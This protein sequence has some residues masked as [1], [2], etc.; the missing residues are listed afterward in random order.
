M[1]VFLRV[2]IMSPWLGEKIFSWQWCCTR[3]DQKTHL[4][5]PIVWD[6]GLANFIFAKLPLWLFWSQS[7]GRV[8]LTS[9]GSSNPT[10]SNRN[11]LQFAYLFLFLVWDFIA[12][13]PYRRHWNQAAWNQLV[14]GWSAAAVPSCQLGRKQ[15][16]GVRKTAQSIC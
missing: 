1:W 15:N 9:G 5:A 4:I 12:K 3:K 7:L 16:T 14:F 6:K 11:W 8:P 10:A 2:P 13:L